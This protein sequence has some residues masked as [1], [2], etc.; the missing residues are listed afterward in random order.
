MA[1]ATQPEYLAP[2]RAYPA[3]AAYGHPLARH[4]G[5]G[6]MFGLHPG[7]AFLTLV[8][9]AMLFGGDVATMGALLPVSIGVGAVLGLITYKAQM[10]W[11]GDDSESAAIKGLIIGFLTAI[12][13]PLPAIFSVPSGILGLV[14]QWRNKLR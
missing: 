5:F 10:R 11:Y 7:I 8:V 13:A 14:H 4:G 12:P 9:D 2:D 1:F 3:A 6:Q